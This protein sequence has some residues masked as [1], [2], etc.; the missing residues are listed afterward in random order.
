MCMKGLTVA[1]RCRAEARGSGGLARKSVKKRASLMGIR[2][3]LTFSNLARQARRHSGDAYVA[4][5]RALSG[6]HLTLFLTQQG[7][8]ET[9]L[10]TKRHPTRSLC[11]SPKIHLKVMGS[12]QV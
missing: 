10:N 5:H 1:A 7:M 2:A 12:L 3:G 9:P 8:K 11:C 6:V 4:S